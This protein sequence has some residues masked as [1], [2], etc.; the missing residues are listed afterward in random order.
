MRGERS[1]GTKRWR[2]TGSV[3]T[4]HHFRG[5]A[6]NFFFDSRSAK[7][8]VSQLTNE[9]CVGSR[10]AP[11]VPSIASLSAMPSSPSWICGSCP[12]ILTQGLQQKPIGFPLTYT[13]GILRLSFA[14]RTGQRSFSDTCSS[15]NLM[16]GF[17]A[18]GST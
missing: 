12:K 1:P 11:R 15:S 17:S 7:K 18:A 8:N 14:L 9:R 6:S 5:S 16:R 4:P 10:T 2:D 13:A 3:R